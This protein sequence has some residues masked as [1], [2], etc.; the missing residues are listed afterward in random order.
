MLVRLSTGSAIFCKT[1]QK[2]CTGRSE[3]LEMDLV[4][5]GD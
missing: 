4:A 1:V 5:C 3:T 2:A